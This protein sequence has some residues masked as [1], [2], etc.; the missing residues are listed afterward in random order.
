MKSLRSLSVRSLSLFAL[1]VLALLAGSGPLAFGQQAVQGTI[2]LPV[3]AKL[4]S[5]MLP[6][7]EYK[8][9]VSLLGETRSI[10]DI[11]VTNRVYVLLVGTSKDAPV[12]SAI[13]MASP[14]GAHNPLPANFVSAGDSLMISAIPFPEYGIVV[15]FYGAS[16]KEAL[17]ARAMPSPSA[18]VSAKA[19]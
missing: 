16:G 15:Q 13:A 14:I 9:T 8:F 18:V 19:D 3:A 10:S 5:T 11:A 6:P 1:F 7:G 17:H 2:T 4:G 12:A